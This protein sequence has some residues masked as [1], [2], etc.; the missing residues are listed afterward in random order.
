MPP[1]DTLMTRLG[2]ERSSTGASREVR[3]K[4][5]RVLVAKE[6]SAHRPTCRAH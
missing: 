5:P 2:A 3:A 4:K 6:I 1:E